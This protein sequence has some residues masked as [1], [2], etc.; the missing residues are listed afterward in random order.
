[1]PNFKEPHVYERDPDNPSMQKINLKKSEEFRKFHAL[2]H[3][4]VF[5]A[6][7]ANRYYKDADCEK[8]FT[9]E[10]VQKFNL[11]IPIEIETKRRKL[12]DEALKKGGPEDLDMDAIYLATTPDK[13]DYPERIKSQFVN[14]TPEEKIIRKINRQTTKGY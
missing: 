9:D 10:E 6:I 13:I 7:K 14:F 11:P 5:Y 4:N 1:M 12:I 3:P 2:G 8:E